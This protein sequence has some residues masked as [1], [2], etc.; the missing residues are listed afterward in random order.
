MIRNIGTQAR[1]DIERFLDKRVFLEIQVKVRENWRNNPQ[2]LQQ[3]GLK[4][5]GGTS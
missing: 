3:F 1:K 5:E 4:Q 2:I